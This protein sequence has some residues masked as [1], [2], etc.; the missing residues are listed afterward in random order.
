MSEYPKHTWSFL[1]NKMT[2]GR[3]WLDILDLTEIQ[4]ISISLTTSLSRCWTPLVTSQR[5]SQFRL[6][7]EWGMMLRSTKQDGS[8]NTY[9]HFEERT[10]ESPA[11]HTRLLCAMRN[12][13]PQIGKL[14]K[15][16]LVLLLLL[17]PS[18]SYVERTTGYWQELWL[19]KYLY[20]HFKGKLFFS[21]FTG[22]LTQ[23]TVVAVL[24][25]E[26]HSSD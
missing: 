15:I 8:L 17:H 24:S 13:S 25:H 12:T 19:G 21:T 22:T 7:T 2:T 3:C 16:S 11:N 26:T 6:L 9:H 4:I 23:L 18:S 20:D 14:A 10:T 1:Q 5:R